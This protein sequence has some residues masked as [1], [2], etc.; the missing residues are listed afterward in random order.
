MLIDSPPNYWPVFNLSCVKYCCQCQSWCIICYCSCVFDDGLCVGH[1]D[2]FK[3]E[4]YYLYFQNDEENVDKE[5]ILPPGWER[6]EG[7]SIVSIHF[8]PYR[9]TYSKYY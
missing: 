5:E 1:M 7:R 6:H 9:Y 4:Y 2:I 3:E 8:E